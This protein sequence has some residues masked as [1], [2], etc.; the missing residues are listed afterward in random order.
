MAL[1]K[2]TFIDL[3]AGIG[4]IRKGFEYIGGKCVFTSEWDKFA[5]IT[6]AANHSETEADIAGDIWSVPLD[7]IPD[8][9]VLVG[10]FPCQPFSLA[11]VSKKNAMGR[12]HGFACDAQ[13]TLFFRVAEILKEK[14]PAAFMLENVKNLVSHNKGHTFRVIQ[15]VLE[16]E[17]GYHISWKVVDGKRWTP[18]H[19]ERIYIVGF[20]EDVGFEWPDECAWPEPGSVKLG[21]IL[22]PEAKVDAKYVLTDKLWNYLQAYRDKHSKAGNGFGCSVVTRNET[23]RT[24]SARYHK[25][26]S[27]I[28]VHRGPGLNPRRLTPRE[29]A[30]LMGF[31]DNFVLPVSDTQLY[32]QFGNSV[33]V[34]AVQA[35]A[36]AMEPY[37]KKALKRNGKASGV[38]KTT[39]KPAAILKGTSNPP[40]RPIK[41]PVVA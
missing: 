10:G 26:G 28:L 23:T 25:D 2:F 16:K 40:S 17:L 8:H 1:P 5:R 35:V 18:Q 9:D 29:C 38:A 11:G 15:H 32:R 24:L 33:V 36:S 19:R 31:E 4:G 6:Y 30:R 37:L 41:I 39:E 12:T 34:P 7:V 21:S 14:R 22:E 3:F 27:E 13:G 20:R